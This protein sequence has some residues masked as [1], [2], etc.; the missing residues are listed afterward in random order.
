MVATRPD[1]WYTVTRMVPRPKESKARLMLFKRHNQSANN[2]LEI[3]ET[4]E[5]RILWL[6]LG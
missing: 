2:I 6:G 4:L 5:I 3:V 1:I